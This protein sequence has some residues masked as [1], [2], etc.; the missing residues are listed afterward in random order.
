MPQLSRAGTLALLCASYVAAGMSLASV[1]PSLPALA[2]NIGRDVAVV[3]GLFTA[4]SLGTIVVQFAAAP[5]STRFGQRSILV[6]GLGLMSLGKFGESFAGS[7]ELLLLGGFIGGLGFGFIL[8]GGSVLTPRLFPAR[9]TSALNLVNFFFG[10]G[11]ILG[12]LLAGWALARFG[13][14]QA[15]IWLGASLLLLLTP[16]AWFA[17]EVAAPPVSHGSA[18]GVPWGLVTLLGVLLLVYSGT[19]IGIGG[20]SAIY[21][22]QGPALAP[23]QAAF[24]VAG[25]WLALTL[26]RGVGAVLALRLRAS[27]LLA[28]AVSLLLAGAVLFNLSGS[29][30]VLAVGALLLMGFAC[31]PIFPTTMALIAMVS[32]GRSTAAALALGIGNAG[33]AIIP[34]LL[35][36]ALTQL[37]PSAATSMIL[38]LS[39]TVLGLLGAVVWLGR[40]G[41]SYAH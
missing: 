3:G 11:S 14:P 41:Q 10:I 13:A 20:W 15:A 27:R 36:L 2:A 19:E 25:F 34:P 16:V 4:F 6:L 23:E 39:A 28:V 35:G 1:G 30:A 22:V 5:L 21:L 38:A 12:P 18:S 9:G 24:A 17:P 31:G 37:G 33:G 26:G 40:R 29:S 7:L 32:A 8:A